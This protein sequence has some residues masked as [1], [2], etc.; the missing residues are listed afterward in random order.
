[1]VCK[2]GGS[3]SGDWLR[4]QRLLVVGLVAIAVAVALGLVLVQRVGQTYRDGLDVAADSAAIAAEATE[5]LE[6]MAE[7]LLAFARAAEE[8]LGEARTVL[9]S[10]QQS[11]AQ[12]GSAAQNELAETT[13][14]VASL[15]ERAAGAIETIERLIPG[16][17]PS[18]GEDLRQIADGLAPVPEELREL[19]RQLDTTA[20]EL[21]EADATIVELQRTVSSLA[22]DLEGLIPTIADLSATADRLVERVDD[23]ESRVSLDLWLARLVVMLIG[24]VFAVGLLLVYRRDLRA[25]TAT[26]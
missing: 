14:G 8:G 21:A 20:T 15:A 3:M 17:R 2:A 23:A 5:P 9:A 1:M 4:G 6:Q 18:A 11:V 25:Q 24:V 7:D 10:A 16:S 13:E 19:G 22:G 12:L 26:A